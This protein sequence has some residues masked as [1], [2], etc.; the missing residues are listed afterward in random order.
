MLD[1]EGTT[2]SDFTFSTGGLGEDILAVVTGNHGLG[3]AENNVSF[4]A[5]SAFNIHEVGVRGGDESF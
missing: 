3:M 2:L 4:V 5:T 1:F